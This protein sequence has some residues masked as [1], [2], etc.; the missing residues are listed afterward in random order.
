MFEVTPQFVTTILKKALE[1]FGPN[2]EKWCRGIERGK[3]CLVYGVYEA[4]SR[5]RSPFT[6]VRAACSWLRKRAAN[7]S[8]CEWNDSRKDYSEVRRLLEECINGH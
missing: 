4:A 5:L 6:D 7:E 3:L 8:L 2:G 1:V